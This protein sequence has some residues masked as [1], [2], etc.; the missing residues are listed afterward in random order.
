MLYCANDRVGRGNLV[1]KYSVP[2]FA[3]FFEGLR[4]KW[5]DSTPF[6]TIVAF[7]FFVQNG[8]FALPFRTPGHTNKNGT[9]TF[10]T[11]RLVTLVMTRL[12][13]TFRY[14]LQYSR[15]HTHTDVI[16]SHCS[17][18]LDASF[19]TNRFPYTTTGDSERGVL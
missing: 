4:I 2:H 3:E 11:G 16:R 13:H 5:R 10:K 19:F 6:F 12:S 15:T 7:D 14:N 8:T 17:G 18:H 9:R 1:L